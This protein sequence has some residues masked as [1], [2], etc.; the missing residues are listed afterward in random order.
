MKKAPLLN[1]YQTWLDDFTRINLCHGLFQQAITQWH[2]L[3]VT[4]CQ[5]EEGNTSV[6]VIPLCLLR[7]IRTHPIADC[8]ITH[9]LI[10]HID[11]PLLPGVLFSECCRLGK[12]RLAEQLKMLFRLHTQPEVRHA[13]ILLCWCE[14]ATG[15][16]LEEWYSLHLLDVDELKQWILARQKVY[17]GLAVLTKDYIDATRPL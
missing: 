15:S 3:A 11:Y 10:K 17:R 14:L 8:N 16:D 6:I 12:R 1:H 7:I 13:L 9:Q 5:H 4:S 2:K